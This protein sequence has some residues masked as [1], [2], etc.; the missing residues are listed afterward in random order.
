MTPLLFVDSWGWLVLANQSDPAFVR[1]KTLHEQSL[2][3]G[4]KPVT[5]NF[6]LDEV[7]TF[8]YAKAP[9][10]LAEKY[11]GGLKIS[12][13]KGFVLLEQ[14]DPERFE[15]AWKLRVKYRDHPRISFTDI[16]S[17]VVMRELKIKQVLTNDHHFEQVNMGFERCPT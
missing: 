12:I 17:F 11:L 7:I 1:V 9:V 16:T 5:T 6:V 15:T 13:Q 14:I 4:L 10:E 3:S 2:K 8:L